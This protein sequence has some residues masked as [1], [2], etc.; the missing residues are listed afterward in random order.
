[1]KHES[2]W[3]ACVAAA[4]LCC[5]AAASPR[6]AAGNVALQNDVFT[7]PTLGA[8]DP[9]PPA[10]SATPSWRPALR[11]IVQ[12]GER[13]MVLVDKSVVELGG[14][15]DGYRLVAVADNKAV[16]AKGRQRVELTLG[17]DKGDAR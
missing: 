16:F 14:T 4:A 2:R 10:A 13:S 15:I 12:S 3:T 1:M 7:R 6:A 9:A 11:A 8:A 5:L 17:K